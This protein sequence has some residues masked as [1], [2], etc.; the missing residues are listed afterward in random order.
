M[1][2]TNSN[3]ERLLTS[4]LYLYKIKKIVLILILFFFTENIY[5]QQVNINLI[6]G[7]GKTNMKGLPTTVNQG[8]LPK[9]FLKDG[10]SMEYNYKKVSLISGLLYNYRSFDYDFSADDIIN[11]KYNYLSLPLE[12][13]FSG[14]YLFWEFGVWNNVSLNQNKNELGETSKY[15]AT[16]VS[17]IGLIL[18]HKIKLG[19]GVFGDVYP[20]QKIYFSDGIQIYLRH[21]MISYGWNVSL[22]VE[23]FSKKFDKNEK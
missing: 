5:S 6:S 19:I 9:I 10:I 3:K 12:I 17:D 21:A 4:N 1:I 16:I 13:G 8:P 18:F 23:L 7:I 15:S 22:K 14:K 11:Y 2:T 20:I